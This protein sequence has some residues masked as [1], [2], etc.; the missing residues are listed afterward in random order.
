MIINIVSTI[1]HLKHLR[2][3][4]LTIGLI[5]L[6]LDTKLIT[7]C[8][9]KDKYCQLL[10]SKVTKIFSLLCVKLIKDTSQQKEV[11]KHI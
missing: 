2:R 3:L 11:K 9:G 5:G 8:E 7:A 1:Y 4:N 6:K 10:Y